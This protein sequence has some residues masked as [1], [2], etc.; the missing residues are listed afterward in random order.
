MAKIQL[1]QPSLLATLALIGL[2]VV[3]N[4][5]NSIVAA[6]RRKAIEIQHGCG[7]LHRPRKWDVFG[8]YGLYNLMK[9]AGQHRLLEF[10]N[11]NF[12]KYG[13]THGG[14]RRGTTT[15]ITMEAENFKAVLATK[16]DDF[17]VQPLRKALLPLLGEGI[18]TTDGNFWQHSRSVLRPQ[19]EKHQV[20]AVD[21]L[22]P[23][24]LKLIKHVPK[25]GST[26][27]LQY[28]FHSL[29]MDTSSDFLTGSSTNLLDMDNVNELGHKFVATFEA[30]LNDGIMRARLGWI[31]WLFP[32]GQASANVAFARKAVDGWV[33][34]AM[35]YKKAVAANE[36]KSSGDKAGYVFLNELA[37]DSTVDAGRVRDEILNILVAGRDTTASLLSSLWFLLARHPDVWTKLKREVDEL[38]GELPTYEGLRD[39]KYLQYCMQETL[40][41]LPPVPVLAKA[42]IRDTMLPTGGGP[43]RK[44][45]IYVRKGSMVFYNFRS[46]MRDED[47]Y[48]NATE[49]RPDR[50]ADPAFRPGWHYVPF[51]GGPRTCLGRSYAQSECAYITV[52]LMQHYH[53]IESRDERP[54]TEKLSATVCNLN[55]TQVGLYA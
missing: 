35:E 21:H 48:E 47:V 15:I 55:G 52:R 36:K 17:A 6:R 20:A 51:N 9:A 13:K 39:M 28:L 54:W 38:N 37:A 3:Y 7:S 49:F 27:D 14:S 23:H 42:A 8:Y 40:R 19:F 26:V 11:D 29:T 43:D 22:E 24:L 16:F 2:Y 46:L 33:D 1:S 41:L 10:W 12:R 25:D 4:T 32:H 30:G 53:K 5:I 45:P 31:Y 44:S 50:W 18:F 34:R